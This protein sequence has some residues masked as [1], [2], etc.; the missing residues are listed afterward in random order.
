MGNVKVAAFNK[1]GARRFFIEFMKANREAINDN[2]LVQVARAFKLFLK[3]NCG[4]DEEDIGRE[5]GKI[6]ALYRGYLNFYREWGALQKYA[7]NKEIIIE[8]FKKFIMA[9]DYILRRIQLKEAAQNIISERIKELAEIAI[10]TQ[11]MP[12]PAIAYN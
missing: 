5:S 1:R 8:F 9:D 3:N 12:L 11:V 10:E 4:W 2:P 7:L 6:T